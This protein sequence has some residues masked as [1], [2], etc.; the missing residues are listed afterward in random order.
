MSR[1]TGLVGFVFEFVCSVVNF[2]T[3]FFSRAL[4]GVAGCETECAKTEQN[5]NKWLFH[6]HNSF[7]SQPPERRRPPANVCVGV[8]FQRSRIGLTSP[9]TPPTEMPTILHVDDWL[10]VAEKPA[11]LLSVPGRG[12]EKADCART[13]IQQTYP[14]A[15][16]VHRLDMSTSGLL[17]FARSKHVQRALSAEFEQGRVHKTYLADVW[18]PPVEDAGLIDLPLVNDWP[19]RPRQKVDHETGKPSQTRFQVL[20]R[21]AQAARVQL[22]PL[23]GRTHQLRVHLAALGHPILGDDLYAHDDALYMTSRLHLHAT[24]LIFRHPGTDAAVTYQSPCPFETP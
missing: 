22:T 14:D 16:T 8:W 3:E 15:L 10:I 13:R 24:E 9:Y 12:P 4:I 5:C 23:T 1:E 19:N 7:I 18:Q 17:L 20:T 11:E 6:F 2:F 21:H